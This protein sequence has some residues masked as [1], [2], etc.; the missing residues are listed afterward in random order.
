MEALRD[1]RDFEHQIPGIKFPH[2][3]RKFENVARRGESILLSR[4]IKTGKRNY[5]FGWGRAGAFLCG[6]ANT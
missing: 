2:I 1:N 5:W 6:I 3:M 4:I